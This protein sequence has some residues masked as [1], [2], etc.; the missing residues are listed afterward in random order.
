MCGGEH[1]ATS[2]RIEILISAEIRDY[3]DTDEQTLQE[4][5]NDELAECILD[6]SGEVSRKGMIFHLK[7]LEYHVA[8][9]SEGDYEFKEKNKDICLKCLHQNSLGCKGVT[10]TIFKGVKVVCSGFCNVD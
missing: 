6:L 7:N 4:R 10:M 1:M 9:D 3:G 5:I 8:Y 2:K